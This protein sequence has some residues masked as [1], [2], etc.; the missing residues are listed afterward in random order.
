MKFKLLLPLLAIVL[1]SC[2]ETK[3]TSET[4]TITVTNPFDP[5]AV[6]WFKTKGGGSI[7]GVAK[8][9][10]K[11][12]ELRFGEE[13]GIE[14]MPNC[15]YTEERLNH[16]YG[17]KNAGFVHVQD[18]I[19]KFTP[20]PEGYH[21]TIKTMCNEDGTFTFENLPAGDYYVIAFMLWDEI[22]GGIMQHV[23][24]SDHESKEIEMTNF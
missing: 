13:F 2:T 6:S 5:A 22:G 17:N 9:K 8:F 1:L 14:L 15:L 11:S 24:L 4:P 20:D 16:I 12:G 19:P 3:K 21:E 7:K 18:G 10:S 23:V